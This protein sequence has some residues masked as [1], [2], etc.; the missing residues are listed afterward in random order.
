MPQDGQ[1]GPAFDTGLTIGDL[2][3]DKRAQDLAN[4]DEQPGSKGNKYAHDTT[5]G[6][7]ARIAVVDSGVADYHPDLAHAVNPRLSANVTTDPYDFRPNGAGDHGTHV[8][9]T[10]AAAGQG[11]LGTAPDAEIVALRVFSGVEG[12]FGDVV[13][14]IV[15]A[16]NVGCDA[17][18]LS[19]GIP[20]D[21]FDDAPEE[22]I[23]SYIEY[24]QRAAD[25]ARANEMVVVNSTGN[26]GLNMDPADVVSLPTEVE[27]VF[28]VS[29]TG[30]VGFLWDGD[31][32]DHQGLA[33]G[34]LDAL[35]DTPAPYTNYGRQ[36]TDISAAGG[37]YD[38]EAARAGIPGWYYDLVLST[39]VTRDE[40]TGRVSVGYGWKAGTSMAA[41]Q[42]SGAV[43]L[44]RSLSPDASAAEVEAILADTAATAD[45]GELYHGAGHLDVRAAVKAAAKGAKGKGKRK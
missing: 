39:T 28:G 18:N 37:N 42:V 14:A 43:A 5:T 1:Q 16:A 10:I 8:A 11:A 38:V 26:E 12:A 19:L 44:V 9:G 6:E 36:A 20:A 17:A 29:A 24:Y 41:P 15:Y 4:V 32:H 2:Q 25:F 33:P 31:E 3:W 40:D 27:N 22:V 30:P 35:P 21:A 45:E 7:G 13:A 23:E 34:K